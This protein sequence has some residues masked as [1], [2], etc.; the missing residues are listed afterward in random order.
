MNFRHL[1]AYVMKW[2][3]STPADSTANASLLKRVAAT[4][5]LVQAN[6]LVCFGLLTSED[7]DIIHGL[8]V[9]GEAFPVLTTPAGVYKAKE[10]ASIILVGHNVDTGDIE[11]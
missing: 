7:G 2:W 8:D 10:L 9:D 1:K 4:F 3:S 5:E 6:V 11:G